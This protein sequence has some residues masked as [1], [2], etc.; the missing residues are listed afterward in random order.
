M[1]SLYL[2]P[3]RTRLAKAEM[4]SDGRLKVLAVDE[5]PS[6]W[7]ALTVESSGVDADTGISGAALAL[8]GMFREAGEVVGISG[9]EFYLVLPDSVFLSV[10]C[11]REPEAEMGVEDYTAATVEMPIDEMSM[12]IPFETRPSIDLV[13]TVFA[14]PK[15]IIQRIVDA[16]GEEGVTL[17]SVE[18]ASVAF[19]RASGSYNKEHFFLEAF[20]D[21][22]VFT[23]YSPLGGMFRMEDPLLSANRLLDLPGSVGN[24]DVRRVLADLEAA[25]EDRFRTTNEG[26]G[27]VFIAGDKK[28][29]AKF[30]SMEERLEELSFAPDI[31]A[32]VPDL[33]APEDWM[34]S[35]GTFLQ[36]SPEDSPAYAKKPT[37]L[38]CSSGNLLPQG[39]QTNA[40]LFR[41]TQRVKK[42]SRV[43]L[44]FGMALLAMLPA[45]VV[46]FDS[47]VVPQDLQ[48]QFE[49]S[50]KELPVMEKDLSLIAKAKQ[51]HCSPM[52]GFQALL[53]PRPDSLRFTRVRIGEGAGAKGVW[54]E[55]DLVSKEPLVFQDYVA[56]MAEDK[57]FSGASIIRIGT[58]SSGYKTATV[59]LRKG[60][61][62]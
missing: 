52:T 58:D 20:S 41:V 50:Q 19:L 27:I 21:T 25:A 59:T 10:N 3:D 6:Y 60:E 22:A 51:E 8:S 9:E 30:P 37:Y 5:L 48:E 31:L 1:I 33:A 26:V 23:A 42:I 38:V 39:M 28:R 62:K 35:I 43:L 4:G 57:I 24:M 53:H 12:A 56:A 45:V 16:A 54:M 40:K 46:Y 29:Y 61:A 13:R 14:I 47:F 18:P 15:E 34:A 44:C 11:V 2:L 49:A 36:E 55:A 17:S 32:S 7:D